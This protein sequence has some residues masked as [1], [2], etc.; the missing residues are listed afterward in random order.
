MPGY[1]IGKSLLRGFFGNVARSI[2][3]II[4][5]TQNKEASAAIAFGAPVVLK[6]DGTGVVN[7]ASTNVAADFAGI[8][9][10][11]V[12]TEGVY[13]S[14]IA[15][16]AANEVMDVLKRGSVIVKCTMDTTATTAPVKGAGVYIRKA[17]GVFVAAAEGVSGADTIALENVVWGQNGVDANGAAELVILKRVK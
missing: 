13:G 2:D 14:N 6:S 11:E 9:V 8:A 4:E 15:N 16:Y 12:K 10:R 3:T 5:A 7:W 1:T 17:T